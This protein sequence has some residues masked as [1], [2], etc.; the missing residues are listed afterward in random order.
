[1]T[2]T[3]DDIT[4][5]IKSAG[6]TNSVIA[7]H[8]SLKSFG[9]VEGGPETVVR[10]FLEAGC[11]LVVPT[12]SYECAV[13]QPLKDYP[14]NGWGN[15][16]NLTYE[17]EDFSPAWNNLTASEMG[18]IPTSIL[19]M[20]NR[21]RGRHPIDSLSAIG[22][23]ASE[24]ITTQDFLN[25]FGPYKW[26]RSHPNTY[27]LLIG[28][29][30]NRATPI[31]FAEELA[32]HRLFRRWGKYE[33]QIV[34]TELGGCSEGFDKLRPV[35]QEIEKTTTVGQSRWLIYPFKDFVERTAAAIAADPEITRC[36]E[37]DCP[38]CP[39]AVRGG[40]IL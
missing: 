15:E 38:R 24:I 5:G 16:I 34:E 37:A 9:R 40:P 25:I 14:Q 31:H 30:F 13:L 35:V 6:L 19:K 23:L 3:F 1:M 18:A 11:T 20:P 29:G 32:G 22:P 8:S 7:L 33:G 12:F 21:V 39:D 4:N 26:M 36:A 10:A 17:P 28:V 27:L 2:V